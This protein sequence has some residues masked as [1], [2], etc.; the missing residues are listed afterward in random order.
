MDIFHRDQLLKRVAALENEVSSLKE[1]VYLLESAGGQKVSSHKAPAPPPAIHEEPVPVSPPK[2]EASAAW[3][4]GLESLVGGKL[5]NRIAI[6]V[7]LFGMGYFL[8]Y[9]FDNHWIGETG[10][11]I[12]GL[13]AGIAF[14]VAGDITMGRGYRYFSQGLS[15]GG[16]AILYLTTFAAA[17]FYHIFSPAAAFG[18][19]VVTALAGGILSVRQKAYSIAVLS[20]LGGFMT[21]FLIGSDSNN[22]VPLLAYVTI[23]NLVVLYLAYYKNWRSLNFLSFFGTVLV[24]SVYKASHHWL[25]ETAAYETFLLVYFAIFG[26]LA[27]FYNIRHS[28]PTKAPD[29][30]LMIFNIGFFLAASLDNL[31]QQEDWHGLFVISLAIIYLAV[32]TAIQK[33]KMGDN[34]LFLSLLGIGLALVTI[35]IPLQLDGD[36]RDIA[37]VAEGIVLIYAGIKAGNQWVSRSGLF[38]LFMASLF[39]L[40]SYTYFYYHK[41]TPLLNTHSASAFLA[42]AGFFL[43][44]YMFHKRQGLAD[45]QIIMW[46]AA[47]Y[48]TVL[49]LR[50]VSLEVMNAVKYYKLDFQA[51]FGVSLS[52]IILA[53]TIIAIGMIRDIKGLRFIALAL[54]G[55]TLTKIMLY[56]LSNLDM[57]FRVLILLIAGAILLG[58]SFIYQ[59]KDRKGDQQ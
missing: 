28:E 21:P 49:A 2:Q 44:F 14:L 53:V 25:A 39:Q 35:A 29:V 38:V 46:P 43:A 51:V 48:G 7:L 12:I 15:G 5:L 6:V 58:I 37:W 23:L 11:I 26:S 47:V 45:R 41:Q 13:L 55:I 40:T 57:V 50:Q 52:W 27:F 9:S 33:K 17:N 10:R 32:S 16:I 54:F 3:R 4:D 22:P 31:Q 8:K 1:K 30:F 42:I 19:L 59:R 20:T 36:W 18:L 56:D 24:Y 34:L